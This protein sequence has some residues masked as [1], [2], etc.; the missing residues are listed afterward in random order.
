M[1]QTPFG[2][3]FLNQFL[4][5]QILMA[6]GCKR[7]FFHSPQQFAKAHIDRQRSAHDERVDEKPDERLGFFASAIGDGR[8]DYDLVLTRMR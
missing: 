8:S 6:I 7:C 2:L 4:E 5:R 3:Y 1:T